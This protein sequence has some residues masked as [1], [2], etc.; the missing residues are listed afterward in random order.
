MPQ[1]DTPKSDEVELLHSASE[2][3][4]QAEHDDQDLDDLV[5][6][7]AWGWRLPLDGAAEDDRARQM[8]KGVGS[9]TVNE[10]AARI[11]LQRLI[12][13]MEFRLGNDGGP[14]AE[15]MDPKTG[16]SYLSVGN[17]LAGALLSAGFKVLEKNL[18]A[19]MNGQD[20]EIA[21]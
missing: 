7:M 12:P 18:L 1:N 6:A 13:D 5:F 20:E 4:S 14:N 19:A 16:H 10:F 21:P 15:V 2:R 8:A 3:A 9:F 11:A 17:T